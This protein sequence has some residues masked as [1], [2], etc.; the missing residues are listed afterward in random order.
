LGQIWLLS[1]KMGAARP[2][3]QTGKCGSRQ[4]ST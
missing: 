4:D 1:Q 2:L 3:L